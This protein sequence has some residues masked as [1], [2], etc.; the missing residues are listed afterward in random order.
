MNHIPKVMDDLIVVL[1]EELT[2]REDELIRAASKVED[3]AAKVKSDVAKGLHIND[4]GE[5]Q[6]YGYRMDILCAR[7]Q[8][9][10]TE[11]K[12]T[13]HYIEKQFGVE[14]GTLPTILDVV[15]AAT[16]TAKTIVE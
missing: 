12:R 7:R 16:A 3:I 14:R 6:Q 8:D 4:G 11:L 5:L 10:V 15:D 13:V 2:D 1:E 9:A